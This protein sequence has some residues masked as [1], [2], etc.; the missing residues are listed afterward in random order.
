MGV[1]TE[2]TGAGQ[3][4]LLPLYCS[5]RPHESASLARATPWIHELGHLGSHVGVSTLR[6]NKRCFALTQILDYV[7]TRLLLFRTQY[8]VRRWLLNVV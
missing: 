5:L 7:N 1:T 2:S 4:W 6:E 8:P 3:R